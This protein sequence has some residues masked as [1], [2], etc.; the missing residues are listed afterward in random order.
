MQFFKILFL[1]FYLAVSSFAFIENKA[2]QEDKISITE[3]IVQNSLPNVFRPVGNW[4]KRLFGKKSKTIKEYPPANVRSVTLSQ[5]NSIIGYSTGRIS[6]NPT[7][8]NIC[9]T[10]SGVIEVLTKANEA[11]KENDTFKYIYKISG[12]KIVGEGSKV[13]WDLSDAEA[14]TYTITAEVQDS[15]GTCG[16]SITMKICVIECFDCK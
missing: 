6:G 15:C 8:K 7:Q 1:C 14:G 12:G 16:Q 5:N 9:L 3:T 11:E 4:I 10:D 13:S 2:Q